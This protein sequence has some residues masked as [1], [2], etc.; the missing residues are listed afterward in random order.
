M[1]EEKHQKMKHYAKLMIAFSLTIM[2]YGVFLDLKSD[3]RLINPITDVKVESVGIDKTQSTI[4]INATLVGDEN[5]P[6]EPAPIEENPKE[7][8]QDFSE[9]S[10]P[11]L[12]STNNNIRNE[13]Q[14]QYG[15]RFN[16]DDTGK[17]LTAKNKSQETFEI[18]LQEYLSSQ[19][20]LLHE[21]SQHIISA[22]EKIKCNKNKQG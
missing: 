2:L 12:Q 5:Y 19:L 20:D 6:K 3:V 10:I 8:I 7:S 14:N 11:T 21:K 15:I 18:L 9:L 4:D 1:Q 16:K 13:I 17:L 22:I